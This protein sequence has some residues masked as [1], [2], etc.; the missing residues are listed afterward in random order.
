[1][2][3]HE[4]LAGLGRP[5]LL[6][7]QNQSRDTK[8]EEQALAGL[9]R[10]FDEDI[11]LAVPVDWN[12][13]PQG[14]R[15]WRYRLHTLLFILPLL[16]RYDAEGDR[17]ALS[18]AGDVII[19]WT[20][21]N[22]TPTDTTSEFAWY[23]MAVAVRAPLISFALLALAHEELLAEHD[24]EVLLQTCRRHADY[25]QDDA[26]YAEGHNHGLFQDE[27]LLILSQHLAFLPEAAAWEQ[28]A[29]TRLG[30]TLR[31]TI[32]WQEGVHLEHSPAYHLSILGMVR[33]LL[34]EFPALTTDLA[35]VERRMTDAA[36]WLLPPD[37][38][39]PPLGDSDHT[40]APAWAQ[41][42]AAETHGMRFFPLAGA[43]A[44]HDGDSYLLQT[45]AYH[46]HAHK[47]ADELSFVLH[48]RG[49]ELLTEA[50]RYGYY[51]NDPARLYARSAAAHNTVTI[52][53]ADFGWRNSEPYGS[54]LRYVGEADG[55]FAV[56]GHNPV[57]AASATH[58]RLLLYKPGV[59]LVIVDRVRADDVHDVEQTLH[60]GADIEA[61]E[62]GARVAYRGEGIVGSIATLGPADPIRRLHRAETE[63]A[64]RGWLFPRD[65]EWT[66][67]TTL[68]ST[69]RAADA[70]LVTV[71]SLQPVQWRAVTVN[72]TDK[73]VEVGLA[74]MGDDRL[75]RVTRRGS[76]LVVA[77]RP[78]PRRSIHVLI[79]AEVDLNLIDG[80]SIWL[81][82]IAQALAS[83]GEVEVTVL[84]R[85]AL[86]RAVVVDEAAHDP[87]IHFLDPWDFVGYDPCIAD[88]LDK[89]TSPRLDS[90]TAAELIA[91]LMDTMG[92]DLVIVRGEAVACAIAE[93]P[94]LASRMWSYITDP[95]RHESEAARATL[96]TL[97]Q[98]AARLVCQTEEARDAFA[99]MTEADAE[100]IVVLP[101]MIS[102]PL[103]PPRAFADQQAPKL[104]YSGKFSP[105]YR[106][107][108]MLEAFTAIRRRFPA[109]ELHVVGDKFHNHPPVDHFEERVT[110]ALSDTPGV[111]WHGGV[112]RSR[113][114]QILSGVDIAVSWRTPEFDESLEL[115]TKILEYAAL[116]IP[117][118]LNPSVVQRRVL[119]EDYPAYVSTEDELVTT[120][121]ELIESPER[122]RQAASRMRAVVDSYSFE[123][124]SRALLPYLRADA[125]AAQ[126]RGTR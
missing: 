111:Q 113:A 78:S 35:D 2:S 1:M 87:R 96:T 122:Y 22:S 67:T 57:V 45:A 40:T 125:D 84:Q 81:A 66:A 68:H 27:G 86:R 88:L 7:P 52:D 72:A 62:F 30:R 11:E 110:S 75:L 51:E 34:A 82:S 91:H 56:E 119:G 76:Q 102:G 95:A 105:P 123:T 6:V 71:V 49:H 8:R 117:V 89:V 100:K 4:R 120:F 85:T 29:R 106:T 103:G 21:A 54:A 104:G 61:V 17:D 37:G 14:S 93:R 43:V 126:E 32:N 114:N 116:G 118:L 94:A 83:S 25:L 59:A 13:D 124:V 44:V 16:H 53:G 39:V 19:D 3:A 41:K 10:V 65:R 42:A 112:S 58:Q 12:Q 107:L 97:Y 90:A 99:R 69:W 121:T 92:F 63:P 15:S 64:L 5:A 31:A 20:R 33:R 26:N 9:Y 36:A 98:R 70:D 60:F 23:D 77:D 24:T 115:S 101:P 108:E 79:Y 48:E 38:K 73:T 46:S 50:G 74:R 55:W 18:C 80:S 47:H 109:A 28:K